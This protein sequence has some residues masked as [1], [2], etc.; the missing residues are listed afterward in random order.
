MIL[1]AVLAPLAAAPLM[2]LAPSAALPL[3]LTAAALQFG[4][5][6][7][8]AA[9]P[10]A[11]AALGLAL[12]A[13]PLGLL[14]GLVASALWAVTA[15]YANGYLQA[16]GDKRP[17]PFYAWLAAC[18]SATAGVAFA[19]DLLTFVVFYELLTLAT[20]PLVVHTR[21][22]EA[23]AAG[24]KYLAY[25]L[26]GGQLLL[27]GAAWAATLAPGAGF[28]SGGFLAGRASA[29][30][31]CALFALFALGFGV[32]AAVMPL[33]GWLPA[34]MAA[35]VPVSALLH[36]V[37]VVKAGAFGFL[38]LAGDV[39]GHGLMREL[40]AD[41]ALAAAAAVTILA[42]S[43]RAL[44]EPNIKRRLAYST[45]GQ[46]SYVVLGAAAG[47]PA[48]MTGAAFHIAAHGLLKITLFFCAGALYVRA[49]AEDVSQLCGVARRMPV[50]MTAFSVAALGLAGLPGLAAFISKWN[51]G[52]GVFEAG[53]GWLAAVL[54]LS[55]VLN[56]AYFFPL[57]HSA[58]LGRPG[59]AFR[60]EEPR[61]ELWAAPALT[62]VGAAALG[63]APGF[64]LWLA[65]GGP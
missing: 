30:Q 12:R 40:G 38:R 62:A 10:E 11:S 13:D 19:A 20:Y 49:H 2:L 51:L 42:A 23:I 65:R 58:F 29:P 50:T 32:K 4:A 36:A 56:L 61:A 34:A 16:T 26:A 25:T 48:A 1:V 37:A 47:T 53:S 24:R 21:K 57:V 3:S 63:L 15:V 55:G 31:L 59:E 41:S 28:T 45:I 44:G 52:W 18:L 27:A 46:L 6:C 5:V 54:A 22:P 39:F 35:P 43:L 17:G 9:S 14:F 33:H 64:I 7:L 8:L 60:F